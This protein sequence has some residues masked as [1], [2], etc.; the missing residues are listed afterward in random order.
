MSKMMHILRSPQIFH[1]FLQSRLAPAADN[2]NSMTRANGVFADFC[3]EHADLNHDRDECVL[4]TLNRFL[5][6]ELE[7]CKSS[8]PLGKPSHQLAQKCK[9]NR[10]PCERF[11]F[12]IREFC[13]ADRV[14]KR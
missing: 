1:Q 10:Q 11:W 9:A 8:L 12:R 14:A 2:T 13:R 5:S 3:K 6:K 4:M 7:K